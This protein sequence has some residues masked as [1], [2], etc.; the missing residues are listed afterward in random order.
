M[1]GAPSRFLRDLPRID[2][3][4]IVFALACTWKLI[5]T[6]W[7]VRTDYKYMEHNEVRTYSPPPRPIWSPPKPDDLVSGARSW[8]HWEYFY[9]GG[10]GGPV[11]EPQLGVNWTL[12]LIKI[13][14]ATL[15]G[16]SGVIL[17]RRLVNRRRRC[18]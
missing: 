4:L 13:A 7:I 16:S 11:G 9:M 10:A 14:L 2:I 17:F 18:R 12:M 1:T 15:I 6:D 8:A 5:V 3:F